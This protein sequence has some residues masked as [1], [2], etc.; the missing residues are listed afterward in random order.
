MNKN[1]NKNIN[2]NTSENIVCECG[3]TMSRNKSFSVY[4]KYFCSLVCLKNYKT[5]ED[6]KR[7]PKIQDKKFHNMSSGFGS[8]CC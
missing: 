5:I 4:S 1:M 7:K 2:N 8:A 3:N 6:E